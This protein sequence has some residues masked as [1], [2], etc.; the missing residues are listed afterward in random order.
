MSDMPVARS[1][2]SPVEP[3]EIANGWL[4]SRRQSTGPLRLADLSPAAKILVKGQH[5]PFQVSYGHSTRTGKWIVAGSGPDE[6]TLIGPPGE[7]F[8]VETVGFATVIDI[9]HGRAL[10]R[11]TGQDGS[12]LLAKLCP[13]DLSDPMCPDGAVFRASIASLVTDVI[14]A[15]VDGVRSYLLHCERSSGQFL[16]D[17]I[18]EAGVEFGIEV[19]GFS[20]PQP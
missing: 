17:A 2:I 20:E 16:F 3:T 9:T 13:I 14:R 8:E 12:G 18:L 15:D 10:M 6:W 11:L 4:I 1:P 7:T 5:P 19:E